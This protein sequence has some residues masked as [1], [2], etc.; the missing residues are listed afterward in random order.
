[1]LVVVYCYLFCAPPQVKVYPE[2][3]DDIIAMLTYYDGNCLSAESDLMPRLFT[4]SPRTLADKQGRQHSVFSQT[5][6]GQKE[7]SYQ[8]KPVS[9]HNM[10]VCDSSAC[11]E[12][13]ASY[14][15]GERSTDKAEWGYAW[16]W[17][18]FTRRHGNGRQPLQARGPGSSRQADRQTEI[19]E[20]VQGQLDGHLLV[21]PGGHLS[22]HLDHW[23]PYRT[24]DE[25]MFLSHFWK[26]AE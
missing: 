9:L 26:R 22:T 8:H 14:S 16:P 25:G 7:K 3:M 17:T 2:S 24:E 5:N 13:E 18:H 1:M 6:E 11:C 15:R 19:E 4:S 21:H 20:H 12:G 23:L 10:C